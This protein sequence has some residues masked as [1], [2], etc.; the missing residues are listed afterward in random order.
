MIPM[1]NPLVVFDLDG[2]LIDTAPDLVASVNHT[3]GLDGLAP[4]TY[5]DLTY[6]V[7]HGAKVMIGRAFA[8]RQAELGAERHTELLGHFVRHYQQGMPGYSKPY[9]G[10]VDALDRLKASGHDLAVCTNKMESL[11]RD[12]LE[13]LGLTSYF[14]V[15]TGGDTFAWRKPDARHLLETVRMAGGDPART[16][17]IGDS[18]NDIKVAQ[19]A[20]VKAIAVPFGYCDVP[21]ETLQPD[22]IIRHFD[23]L[24]P[25]LV[26]RIL[27]P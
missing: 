9:P 8:L 11:A 1:N 4:V 24:T 26:A 12:L 5:S 20:A 25:E 19:N 3:I 7:G 22:Y 18:S 2:T 27:T 13:S 10:L 23:E 14:P 6:L 15:I 16:I 17:M 21:I